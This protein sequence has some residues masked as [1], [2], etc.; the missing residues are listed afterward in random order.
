M[1]TPRTS[2]SA[3]SVSHALCTIFTLLSWPCDVQWYLLDEQRLLISVWPSLSF[4]SLLRL[5][6]WSPVPTRG[7]HW[8][9]PNAVGHLADADDISSRVIFQKTTLTESGGT[10]EEKRM[11]IQPPVQQGNW[12]LNKMEFPIPK[13]GAS[14]F[15]HSSRWAS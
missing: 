10:A 9:E 7:P 4:F 2:G 8:Q 13:R 11:C 14:Y 12:Q 3:L 15:F 1:H 6:F 5:P